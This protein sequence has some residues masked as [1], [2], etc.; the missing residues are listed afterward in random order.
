MYVEDLKTG[1]DL[2]QLSSGIAWEEFISN[3]VFIRIPGLKSFH[4]IRHFKQFKT[5]F[6]LRNTNYS[7]DYSD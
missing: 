6:L 2:I 7:C 3:T 4:S 5:R 1:Q